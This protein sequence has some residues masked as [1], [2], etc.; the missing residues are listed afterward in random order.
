MDVDELK[1]IGDEQDDRD[2]RDDRDDQFDDDRARIDEI[3]DVEENRQSQQTGE[4]SKAETDG[5]KAPKTDPPSTTSQNPDPAD[6]APTEK[7]KWK[8]ANAF[9]N[10]VHDFKQDYP[11]SGVTRNIFQICGERWK[12][13]TDE[14]KQPYI[15]AANTVK[16]LKN[17]KIGDNS[18]NHQTKKSTGRVSKHKAEVKR[19]ETNKKRS[20]VKLHVL[21]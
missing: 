21:I 20:K 10:F 15:I 11:N 17:R 5:K 14:Q 18:N 16:R 13:M 8:S 6:T 7:T 4:P 3:D 9:V 12:N 1:E 19:K 2:D